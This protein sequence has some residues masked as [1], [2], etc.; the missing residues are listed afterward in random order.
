MD[1]LG[2]DDVGGYDEVVAETH[3]FEGLFEEIAG[4]RGREVGEPVIATEG[5]EVE[6]S[7][8]LV[9]DEVVGHGWMVEEGLV[10]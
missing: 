3:G 8:G 2:H 4:L 9:S 10:G 6:V 1:V 7:C 5:D